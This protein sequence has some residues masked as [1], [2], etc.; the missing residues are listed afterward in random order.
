MGLMAWAITRSRHGASGHL[1]V[2]SVV[3]L[4]VALPEWAATSSLGVVVLWAWAEAL[5][6][7]VVARKQHLDDCGNQEEENVQDSQSE[8]GSVQAA[9]VSP[10]TGTRSRLAGEANTQRSVD[11]AFARVGTM[12]RVVCNG[13]KAAN[14]ADVK[15]DSDEREDRDASEEQGE[16]NTEDG[17]QH[18]GT[19]NALN[20]LLPCWDVDIVSREDCEVVAVNA[21]DDGCRGELNESQASLAEAKKC[22]TEGHGVV[23]EG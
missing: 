23:C 11:N 2:A 17:V 9:D 16:Q 18:T 1:C 3:N 19:G 5:L 12:A 22:S 15:E 13:S 14:E 10:V 20:G 7:L 8:A 6:F 21:E 4:L